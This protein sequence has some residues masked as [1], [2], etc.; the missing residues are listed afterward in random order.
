MS[1]LL[2][3]HYSSY[4]ILLFS[5]FKHLGA[6]AERIIKHDIAFIFTSHNL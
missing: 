5:D 6:K 2:K 4:N 3:E 1:R